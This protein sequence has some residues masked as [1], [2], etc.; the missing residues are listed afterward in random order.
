MQINTTEQNAYDWS[1]VIP[2]LKSNVVTNGWSLSQYANLSKGFKLLQSSTQGQ[3]VHFRFRGRRVGIL[4]GKNVNHGKLSVDVDGTD[5]GQIDCSFADWYQ[6]NTTI[7]YNVPFVIATDLPEGE[8]LLTITKPDAKQTFICGFLVDDAGHA[9]H[10]ANF[11]LHE[12]LDNTGTA[13]QPATVS[14][15]GTIIRTTDTWLLGASFSNTTA[16]PIT[17]TIT[18][19][20]GNTVMVFPVPANDMRLINAPIFLQGTSKATASATGVIM[21]V[22]GQ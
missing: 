21:T 15:T 12:M 11:N 7:L 8:H 20:N 1:F 22:G 3:Y 16:S 18:N 19:G 4:V 9:P 13:N 2:N 17:I 5:Y 6:S 14:T 10:T